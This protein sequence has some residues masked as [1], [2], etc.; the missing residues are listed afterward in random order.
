MIRV[1]FNRAVL[2]LTREE[3]A[4]AVRRGKALRRAETARKREER[5]AA[6]DAK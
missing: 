4:R 5:A 1:P 2:V 3:F 6:S